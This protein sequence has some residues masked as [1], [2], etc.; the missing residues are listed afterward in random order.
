[1][2]CETYFKEGSFS[3]E[4]GFDMMNELFRENNIPTAVFA[5]NDVIAL[6]AMKA[7]RENGLKIPDI[8][9]IGFN[10]EGDKCLYYAAAHHNPCTCIRYGTA[11]GKSCICFFKS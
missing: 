9:I 11:R 5:A 8:S 4:S 3:F 10:D 6:G 1:M 7:I 2:D